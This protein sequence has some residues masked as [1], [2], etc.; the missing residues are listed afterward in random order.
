MNT[1]DGAP[2]DLRSKKGQDLLIYLALTGKPHPREHLE[3]L[4][5]E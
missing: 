2:V 5:S 3:T 4:L 1:R